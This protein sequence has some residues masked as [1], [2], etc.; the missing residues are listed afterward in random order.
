MISKLTLT[1]QRNSV[2]C[3]KTSLKKTAL[4][5][6]ALKY[7]KKQKGNWPRLAVEC[8]VSIDWI[9]RFAQGG[10]ANPGAKPIERL[11]RHGGILP[12]HIK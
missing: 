9:R 10:I 4:C 11:L 12:G 5:D 2:G 6:L 7:L 8:G 3:M 1:Q